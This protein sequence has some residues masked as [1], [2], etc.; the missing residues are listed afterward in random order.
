M[1]INANRQ[2]QQA[3]EGA[4]DSKRSYNPQLTGQIKGSIQIPGLQ[5]QRDTTHLP[6]LCL[7]FES[8]PIFRATKTLK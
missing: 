3:L 7:L 4:A 2:M 1:N 6:F 5:E 8:A